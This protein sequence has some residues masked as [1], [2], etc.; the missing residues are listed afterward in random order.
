MEGK[1]YV[2]QKKIVYVCQCAIEVTVR[3][4]DSV[5]FAVTSISHAS[6]TYE[7]ATNHDP[8]GDSNGTS[9]TIAAP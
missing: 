6:Y 3:K 8:D 7:P 9:I 1:H 4:A 5:T 2:S